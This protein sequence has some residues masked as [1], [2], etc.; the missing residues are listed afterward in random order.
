[1]REICLEAASQC[2]LAFVD[3]RPAPESV[4]FSIRQ[5]EA[6]RSERVRRRQTENFDLGSLLVLSKAKHLTSLDGRA[7]MDAIQRDAE[8][9]VTISARPN[10]YTNMPTKIIEITFK[11]SG[12][13]ERLIVPR[14]S[15]PR[16]GGGG[17]AE[18]NKRQRTFARFV[19]ATEW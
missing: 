5:M 15:V 12:T 13:F 4:D 19:I 6:S 7:L 11:H 2:F 8:Y 14:V 17:A 9:T 1:M 16:E 10:V 18:G 3:G